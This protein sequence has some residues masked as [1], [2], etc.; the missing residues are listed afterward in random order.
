MPEKSIW[1]QWQETEARIAELQRELREAVKLAGEQREQ[2]LRQV[3]EHSTGVRV[4]RREAEV[5]EAFF[6]PPM[7]SNKEIA[8][9]LNVSERTIKFHMSSL[10]LKYGVTDRHRL[11]WEFSKFREGNRT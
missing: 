7:L 11:Y 1:D 9:K 8:V 2:L 4:T 3:S 10:L 5:L 6:G